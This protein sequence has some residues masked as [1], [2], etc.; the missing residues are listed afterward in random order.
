MSAFRDVQRLSCFFIWSYFPWWNATKSGSSV[1]F[2]QRSHL[3]L[4]ACLL[5]CC[6]KSISHLQTPLLI[7]K[8][9]HS[10]YRDLWV[11]RI[12]STREHT[13]EFSFTLNKQDSKACANQNQ[14]QNELYCQVCLHKQGICF[15]DRSYIAGATEWE[16]KNTDNKKKN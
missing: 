4:A 13:S 1:I 16:N 12:S 2:S 6:N 3:I 8:S 9:C 11:H 7:C 15:R 10:V 14:N 5:S